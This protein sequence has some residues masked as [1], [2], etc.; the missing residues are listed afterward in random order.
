MQAL[1]DGLQ[2]VRESA[3]G[4]DK[5]NQET[6]QAVHD[7]L[8]QIVTKLA[9]LE[10]AAVGQQVAAAAAQGNQFAAPDRE[11]AEIWKDESHQAQPMP[12]S[13]KG[14]EEPDWFHS[15]RKPR[16]IQLPR[17]KPRRTPTRCPIGFRNRHCPSSRKLMPSPDDAGSRT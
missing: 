4:A 10:T 11:Q 9:E 14:L 3:I 13:R 5:R 16:S 15:C 6:L 17:R 8:E 2:A 12:E 7:T 1:E